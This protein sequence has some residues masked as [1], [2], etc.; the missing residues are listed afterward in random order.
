MQATETLGFFT[1][2]LPI[3]KNDWKK[4]KNR[5]TQLQ[6]ERDETKRDEVR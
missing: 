1:S 5:E 6:K 4:K 3:I 2:S